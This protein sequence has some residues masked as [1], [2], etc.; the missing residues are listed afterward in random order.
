[1]LLVTDAPAEAIIC[2]RAGNNDALSGA[3]A[4]PMVQL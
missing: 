1:V 3:C 4:E 2:V